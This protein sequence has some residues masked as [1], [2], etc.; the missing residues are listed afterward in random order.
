MLGQHHAEE[1]FRSHIEKYGVSV[2][3][4]TELVSLEQDA[5][6]VTAQIV[7]RDEDGK[8][9]KESIRTPFLIGADG[10]R[11]LLSFAPL[12]NCFG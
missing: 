4:N 2:E 12:M 10:A 8:E 9:V 3:L 5:D 6:G 11:G 7:R 1:I